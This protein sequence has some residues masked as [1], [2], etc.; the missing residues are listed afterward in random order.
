[1]LAENGIL[2]CEDIFDFNL[3]N[4]YAKDDSVFV[5]DG[6]T[7][8]GIEVASERHKDFYWH[9][10]RILIKSKSE[11]LKEAK[12]HESKPYIAKLPVKQMSDYERNSTELAISIPLFPSELDT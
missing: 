5:I 8:R 2:V 9:E 3:V 11:K 4:R 6:W 12:V 1:M 7:N 10:E